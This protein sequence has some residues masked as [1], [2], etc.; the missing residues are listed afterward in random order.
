MIVRLGKADCLVARLRGN[1][2][3]KEEAERLIMTTPS[4]TQSAA[5]F[6]DD[7]FPPLTRQPDLTDAM[8]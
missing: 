6:S 2:L 5:L 1:D 7:V 8:A 4:A 3:Y